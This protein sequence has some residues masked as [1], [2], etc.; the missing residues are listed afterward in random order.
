MKT[1]RMRR[2]IRTMCLG[3]C[4]LLSA[5][6]CIATRGWVQ[7]QMAPLGRQVAEVE[8]RLS[9]TEADAASGTQQ[10]ELA[11]KN[12]ENLHLEQHFVLSVQEGAHFDFD[13]ADLTVDTQRTIDKFFQSL[14]GT[15][16]VIFLV[17]GHT[18]SIGPEDHNYALGQK[19][20]ASVARYLIVHKGINPLQVTAV[21]YGERLPMADND[22]SYG[23]SKNRRVEI[24]IYKEIIAST[25][26]GQ[27]LELKGMRGG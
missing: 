12:L 13:A 19:R 16:D 5:S 24:K 10:A 14:H 20:A 2:S 1:Q 3:L 4:L 8:T 7:E 15:S 25:P 22:T 21:S 9:Q 26:G 6:G 27:R 11:L 23:R 18:D 17:A